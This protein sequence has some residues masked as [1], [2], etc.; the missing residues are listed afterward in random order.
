MP[1]SRCDVVDGQYFDLPNKIG[2]EVSAITEI[3]AST[4]GA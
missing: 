4:M 1:Q 2:P 3:C